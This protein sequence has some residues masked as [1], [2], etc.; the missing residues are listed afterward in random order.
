MLQV[1]P[2][3]HFDLGR[4]DFQ[5]RFAAS[6]VRTVDKNMPVEST[7]SHQSGVECFGAVGCSQNDHTL[8]R[9]KSIHLHQKGIQGLV[10]FFTAAGR[11][12]TS[13]L[14]DGVQFVDENNRGRAL[15]GL[16]EHIANASRADADE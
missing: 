6:N 4:M 9:S 5:D 3:V 8:V 12:M 14:A 1:H 10:P 16:L 13:N 7:R 11:A 15:T 2:F